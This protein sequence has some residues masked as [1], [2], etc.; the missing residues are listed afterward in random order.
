MNAIIITG[1]MRTYKVPHILKS[2]INYLQKWGKFDVFIHTWD[3]CGKSNN[4]GSNFNCT[5]DSNKVTADELYKH[6]SQIPFF[7]VV[8][9]VVESF[10]D[11]VNSL[12][13][14]MAEIYNTP[15]RDHSKYTTSLCIEYK[16]QAGVQRFVEKKTKT[17]D[18]VL[19]LR[20]DTV[21]INEIPWNTYTERDTLYFHTINNRCIDHGW[22]LDEES[23]VKLFG[24]IYDNYYDNFKNIPDKIIETESNRDNNE[25]L[26]YE[27]EKKGIKLGHSRLYLFYI[28]K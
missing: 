6:Y 15:F 11:W 24:T 27:A 23:A 18:K 8:D 3:T 25:I 12:E 5:Y 14:K 21:F 2:Y 20:A 1:Q 16:Y 13:P 28:M 10:D 26:R 9:V 22:V 4:H 19:F 17:Y 7:N